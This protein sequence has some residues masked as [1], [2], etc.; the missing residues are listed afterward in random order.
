MDD[1]ILHLYI[2][3]MTT[4]DIVDTFDEM[5]GAEIS[6]TLISRATNADIDQVIE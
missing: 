6:P 3:G 1:K 2:K 4:R 5:Y